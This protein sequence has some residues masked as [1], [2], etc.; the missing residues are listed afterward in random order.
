MKHK[1]GD[2]LYTRCGKCSCVETVVEGPDNDRSITNF[3]WRRGILSARGWCH[4]AN[5]VPGRITYM[6]RATPSWG[7]L[8]LQWKF[9]YRGNGVKVEVK[10]GV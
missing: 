6:S 10:D 4:I 9:L 8:N 3:I 7:Y 2:I 5:R 1:V